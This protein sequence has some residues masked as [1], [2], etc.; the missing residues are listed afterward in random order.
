ME[1]LKAW[2]QFVNFLS[3]ILW[4]VVVIIFYFLIIRISIF[5]IRYRSKLKK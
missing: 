2:T 5:I 1:I 3:A 4:I